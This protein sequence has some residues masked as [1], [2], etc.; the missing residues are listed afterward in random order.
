MLKKSPSGSLCP[1]YFMGGELHPLKYGSY[2]ND[3]QRLF[4]IIDLEQEFIL[5]SSGT[6]NRLIWVDLYETKIDNEVIDYLI[7]HLESIKH[8]INKIC[9]V[10][11]KLPVQI[12]IKNQLKNKDI[13]LYNKIKYFDDPEKS[14]YWLVNK[15]PV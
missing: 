8:K 2:H 12:K 9:L 7:T 13:E 4:E 6:N 11:C 5:A 3:K 1:Y 10:G 14:K 15:M